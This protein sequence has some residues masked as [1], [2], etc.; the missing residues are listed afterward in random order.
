MMRAVR[1]TK[2]GGPEVLKVETNVPVPTPTQSQVNSSYLAHVH[3]VK[4]K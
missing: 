4:S 1:V 3:L 2:F